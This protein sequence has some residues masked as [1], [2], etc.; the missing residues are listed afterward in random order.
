M[1]RNSFIFLEKINSKTEQNIWHQDIKDWQ[2]FINADKVKGISNKRKHY[3]NMKIKEAQK[4]L[5]TFDSKYFTNKLPGTETWR[6]YDF[7]KEDTIFLDIEIANRKGDISVIGI[8]DGINT[9]VMVKGFN[10]DI[11]LLKE[12]L[13]KAKL[14]VTFNGSI[15]DIPVINRYFSFLPNIPHIDL[16][17]L[18]QKLGLKGSLKDIE[19][20]IGIKRPRHLRGSP[21]ELWK[22]YHASG[23]KEYLQLLVQYNEED[24]V[25]LK[26]LM[27]YCYKKLK[28]PL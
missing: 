26:P 3:F 23:D 4:A 8:Y 25:N 22:A 10:L 27:E 11:K 9:K 21:V 19:P 13:A 14:I 24:M 12:I 16:R 7:F 1:I 15:F 6:L 2:S 5:Y 20:K 28:Q 18:C 17:F